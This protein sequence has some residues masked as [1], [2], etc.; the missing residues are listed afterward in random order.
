MK[1][2]LELMQDVKSKPFAQRL[3]EIYGVDEAGVREEQ[4][5]YLKAIDRF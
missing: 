4:E 5:R 2:I 1:T 3:A